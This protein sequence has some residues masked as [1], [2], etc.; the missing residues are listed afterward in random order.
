[1]KRE[2]GRRKEEVVFILGPTSSGK[3][4]VAAGLAEKLGGEINSIFQSP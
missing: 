1:M 3:S 4:E 2:E